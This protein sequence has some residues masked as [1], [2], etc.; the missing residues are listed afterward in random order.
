MAIC[1]SGQG[2]GYANGLKANELNLKLTEISALQRNLDGRIALA[3]AK[4]DQLTQK[5]AELKQEVRDQHAQLKVGS[6]QQAVLNPRINYNLQLIQLLLGYVS[7]LDEKI[8]YFQNGHAI[9]TFFFQQAQ[10]DRLLIKTLNDFE[11]DKLIAQ[12][13]EVLDEYIPATSKPF[14][15]VND[16]PIKSTEKIWQEIVKRN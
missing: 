10:D 8:V 6:Y 12:I 15:D 5:T 13:N 11:I 7:R 3:M 9:L 14:F 4:K 1:M 2:S 16:V